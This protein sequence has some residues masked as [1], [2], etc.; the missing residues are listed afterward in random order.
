M[1][2]ASVVNTGRIIDRYSTG[3]VRDECDTGRVC[4]VCMYPLPPCI[5]ELFLYFE[6]ISRTSII[7]LR[8]LYQGMWWSGVGLKCRA[9]QSGILNTQC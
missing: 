3:K 9:S 7:K 6:L 1:L 8:A 4:D 5:V 2:C